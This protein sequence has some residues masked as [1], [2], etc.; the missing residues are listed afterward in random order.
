MLA[1]LPLSRLHGAV[2]GELDR[3]V[4]GTYAKDEAARD[5]PR[6]GRYGAFLVPL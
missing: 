4:L 1:L 2:G 6:I 3:S 5:A